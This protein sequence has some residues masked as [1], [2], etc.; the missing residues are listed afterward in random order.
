[1]QGPKVPAA[2][3][4]GIRHEI[5]VNRRDTPSS[6]A[7]QERKSNGLIQNVLHSPHGTPLKPDLDTVRM[8]RRFGKNVLNNAFR[9]S[10]SPLVLLQHNGNPQ[11]GPDIFP[12]RSLH[13]SLQKKPEEQECY[14]CS[15]KRTGDYFD[16]SVHTRIDTASRYQKGKNENP[17]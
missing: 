3:S 13:V 9:Q 11:P 15:Q 5:P 4:V 1:M 2:R 17:E 8:G 6:P 12:F 10:A 7:G 16:R 14:A